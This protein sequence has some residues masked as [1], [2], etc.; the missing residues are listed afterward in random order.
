MLWSF[1]TERRTREQSAW[2]RVASRGSMPETTVA[3]IITRSDD[4]TRILLTRRR[5]APFEGRWCLPG[6]HIDR[7]E[8]ARVAVI[9]EVREETGLDYEARFYRYFD[10][11]I[12]ER[13]IHAVVLAF[14]GAGTGDLVPSEGEVSEIAWFP[15]EEARALPL[16]FR[17]GEILG[18]YAAR[19]EEADTR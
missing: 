1:V 7:F 3:A 12:P 16:A 19:L 13:E 14:E 6:G 15:Q 11:I 2:E 18:A 10:E 17:H 8:A 9:R 4:A 5:I